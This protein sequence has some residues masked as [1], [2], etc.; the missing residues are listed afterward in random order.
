M[1]NTVELGSVA[2]ICMPSFKIGSGIS[3]L[4]R[5]DTQT[6]GNMSSIEQF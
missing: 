6:T 1:K 5:V 4:I 2:M 3:K